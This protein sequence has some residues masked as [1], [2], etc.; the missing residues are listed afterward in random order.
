MALSADVMPARFRYTTSDSLISKISAH[1]VV[2]FFMVRISIMA[3]A[4]SGGDYMYVCM[5]IT[6][7]GAVSDVMSNV[8]RLCSHIRGQG[9]GLGRR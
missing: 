7:I 1:S 2:S 4:A 8:P 9:T 5:E 6:E 3:V